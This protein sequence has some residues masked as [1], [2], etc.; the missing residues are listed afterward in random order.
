M[1]FILIATFTVL[2]FCTNAQTDPYKKLTAYFNVI[3]TNNKFMGS[4]ALIQNGIITYQNA[5]GM[6]NVANATKNNIFTK[7]RVGSISKTFTA[8]LIMQAIEEKKINLTDNIFKYYPTIK[9][10][11]K[12]TIS[13]LLNHHSGIHNFT[14]DSIYTTYNTRPK[15]ELQMV[16]IIAKAGVDFEP[17]TKAAYSN[18]NY[19][20]LSYILQ[21]IYKKNYAEILNAKIIKPLKLVNT[22]VGK[23]INVKNNEANS[24]NFNAGLWVKETETDMS[25]PM[26]AGN[27]VSTP[28]DLVLFAHALFNNKLINS[29]SLNFMTKLID[30]YGM[31][32]GKVPFNNKIGYGH[33]GGIDGFSSVFAYFPDDKV[34]YALTCN[35]SNGFDNNKISIAALSV[36]F[37]QPFNIPNFVLYP[38]DVVELESYVGNYASSQ[39]PLKLKVTR[40]Q[41]LLFAQATG[42]AAFELLQT[43]KGKFTFDAAGIILDFNAEA[44]TMQLKQ[45]GMEYTFIKE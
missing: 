28:T 29:T 18:S 25:I 12:I 1:K 17:N 33:T 30:K 45:G 41:K 43:S 10:A 32:L 15:T 9:N 8:V 39:I 37:N 36:P 14:N 6:C 21:K 23:N 22:F 44:K 26:G 3:D 16:A 24:Y 38:S 40:N 42:Q 19:I 7:F 35:G 27:I 20:L 11:K 13:N 34:G 31:G 4:A 2:N 5:V